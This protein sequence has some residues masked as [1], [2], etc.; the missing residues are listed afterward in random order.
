ML[1]RGSG[2]GVANPKNTELGKLGGELDGLACQGGAANEAERLDVGS[3][4][5]Q[6]QNDERRREY[7]K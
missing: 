6:L 2:D 1:D 3:E 7:T 5:R 4:S